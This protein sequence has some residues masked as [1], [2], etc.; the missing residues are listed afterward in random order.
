MIPFLMLFTPLWPILARL[1]NPR[2][3]DY[4]RSYLQCQA[5]IEFVY[6]A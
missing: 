2:M 4:S 1:S 3:L 6:P 5:L